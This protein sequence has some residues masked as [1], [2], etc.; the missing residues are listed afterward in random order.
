M[1]HKYCVA[2]DGT[3]NMLD[4]SHYAGVL[5]ETDAEMVQSKLKKLYKTGE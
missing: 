3:K 5:V 2:V 4:K 1:K